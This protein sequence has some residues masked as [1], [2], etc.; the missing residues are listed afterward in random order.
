MKKSLIALAA[1]AALSD[2]A[3]AQTSSITGS[4]AFST[5]ACAP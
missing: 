1:L 5:P 3:L 2:A 4:T